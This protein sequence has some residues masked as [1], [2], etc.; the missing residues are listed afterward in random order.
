[1][2]RT[3]S[4][5][6]RLCWISTTLRHSRALSPVVINNVRFKYQN[7]GGDGGDKSGRKKAAMYAVPADNNKEDDAGDLTGGEDEGRRNLLD[8][9]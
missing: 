3:L 8:D 2:F 4:T 7:R 6:T 5:I 9:K 1:M